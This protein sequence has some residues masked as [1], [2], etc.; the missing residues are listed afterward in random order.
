MGHSFYLETG[1]TDPAYNLAFEE[2]VL[3]NAP[4]GDW[5][6]LWQNANAIIVGRNQ[7]ALEEINR[8]FVD[9]HHIKVIRRN[10]GG[11]TVYHDMG[12]L[13]YS[14]ITDDDGSSA[15]RFTD[16]VVNALKG[17][18]LDAQSSGRNDILVS[19]RKVSG[20]AQHRIG[21][22][23]LH[24]GTL[25]FDSNPDMIAGSLNPD[26]T[27]FTSKS[28]KSV[29]SRVGNIRD[30]LPR[31][32]TISA[33]WEYLKTALADSIVPV[34]LSAD[35]LEQVHALKKEKYDTWQWNFGSSPKFDTQIRK[36]FD[37]GLLQIHLTVRHGNIQDLVIFG[38]FL[39]LTP[40]DPL[41]AAL[42]GCRYDRAAIENAICG[43]DLSSCL[44]T[45]TKDELVSCILNEI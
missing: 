44:G 12:N 37:G 14:F 1:S 18:G 6:I 26:P 34:C 36:R 3:K 43:I 27:K 17:L 4:G 15:A 45:I 30:F 21:G 22:R 8:E 40:I 19:G 23:I 2:F 33:F 42:K 31:D 35:E 24:H 5:L 29:R 7:N 16:P 38:D 41:V 32:M 20:T 39:S 25:L 10:T 28:V 9:A 11:G 13:N